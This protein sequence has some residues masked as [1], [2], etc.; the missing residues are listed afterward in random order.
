VSFSDAADGGMEGA[1]LG[2]NFPS[3]QDVEV[4]AYGGSNCAG[5]ANG[6]DRGCGWFGHL[7]DHPD[8]HLGF[9]GHD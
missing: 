6:G 7:P 3:V 9:V 8:R 4:C 2:A 5:G 1:S